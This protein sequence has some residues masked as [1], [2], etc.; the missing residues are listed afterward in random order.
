MLWA[1]PESGQDIR[2]PDKEQTGT[3]WDRQRDRLADP[4]SHKK[5]MI[6][7]G[8]GVG[9][10]RQDMGKGTRAQVRP[11]SRNYSFC[12]G[13]VCYTPS[14]CMRQGIPKQLSQS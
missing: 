8:V 2:S 12:L 6:R 4:S 1:F 5:G 10:S 3:H 11:R 14:A 7:T 13:H 9:E